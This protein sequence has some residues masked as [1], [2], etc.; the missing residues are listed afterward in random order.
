MSQI[1]SQVTALIDWVG[2]N[3][4]SINELALRITN[5]RYLKELGCVEALISRI[6]A[7]IEKC[8]PIHEEW[9]VAQDAFSVMSDR[10]VHPFHE[11]PPVP[12]IEEFYKSRV[13]SSQLAAGR[14]QLDRMSMGGILLLEDAAEWVNKGTFGAGPLSHTF[15]RAPASTT[16]SPSEDTQPSSK[17]VP[18]VETFL[19]PRALQ[20]SRD[21]LFTSLTGAEAHALG[22]HPGGVASVDDV[23][24]ALANVAK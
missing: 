9:R 2:A 1:E 22:G 21:E 12:A 11:A 5:E 4:A 18:Q 10:L 3:N 14:A 19:L 6:V 8:E 13:N 7:T 16:A 17:I 24:H 20:A 15:G 23:M